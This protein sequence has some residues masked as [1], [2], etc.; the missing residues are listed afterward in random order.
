MTLTKKHYQRLW[1]PE[2]GSG[3]AIP[4]RSEHSMTKAEFDKAMPNEFWRE[5]VDRVAKDAPDTLLLAEAFW[6]MEGY[7]VRSLGM[8]RV[9]NSAFMNMLRNEDNPGYRTLIKNTLEFDPDILKRYVNF[10]NNPDERTT[11]DQFG[12]G[13]KYF[14]ICTLMATLP[15]LPMFGHGQIEGF[16]EKY[17]MEFRKALWDETV[18][19]DLVN[20]HSREIFPLLHNRALFAGVEEFLFYD[21]FTASGNVNEDVYAYTNSHNKQASLVVFNNRFSDTSGWINYSSTYKVKAAKSKKQNARRRVFEGL[22]LHNDPDTFLVFRD[23]TTG[24]QFIRPVSEIYEK[25][26]YLN[27]HAYE[28]HVFLDFQE[29]ND[30]SWNTYRHLHDFLNGRGVPSIQDAM[31]VLKLEPVLHPLQEIFN[32]DYLQNLL[33]H[34]FSEKEPFHPHTR[35]LGEAERKANRLL[36]GASSLSN[37]AAKP[38]LAK[39]ISQQLDVVL[40]LNQLANRFPL[41]KSKTYQKSIRTITEN[42]EENREKWLVLISWCFL[43]NLGRLVNPTD[44][45]NQTLSWLDEWQIGKSLESVFQEFGFSSENS[46]S[47]VNLIRLLISQQ[48]WVDKLPSQSMKELLE[49]WL[50]SPEIQIKIGLNRFNDSLWFNIESFEDFLWWMD[51][52]AVLH[53]A[54][55]PDLDSNTIIES[56]ISTDKIVRKFKAAEKKSGYQ[57]Q[58]LLARF[59]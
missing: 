7:F 2:P 55:S 52:V 39:E 36:E 41:P 27:L 53:A 20:R 25:G 24:L 14:G 48:D 59:E 26:F 32:R 17:G 54:S 1:F 3:G 37:V 15:G 23:Q 38:A 9:Y 18:D 33:E 5:V 43:H 4:S 21:F 46:W 34:C 51:I 35:L 42:L 13:D 49:S 40:S 12:K 22:N 6:L 58:K 19:Q 29:I 31:K 8:H 16:S 11:V 30:D 57:V 44:Y 28:Y 50:A 56:I 10:M 47:M 45:A